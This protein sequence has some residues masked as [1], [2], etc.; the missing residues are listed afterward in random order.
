MSAGVSSARHIKLR[1]AKTKVSSRF[2]A[3]ASATICLILLLT[4]VLLN[5]QVGF[6]V[7]MNGEELGSAK[8]LDTVDTVVSNAEAKLTE[9]LGY[10]YD[11][12]DSISLSTTLVTG[13]ED[14]SKQLEEAI[15]GGIEEIASR[16]VIKVNGAVVGALTDENEANALLD[17]I[18]REY[19]TPETTEIGFREDVEIIRDYVTDDIIH[20]YA[21]LFSALNPQNAYSDYSL[22]VVAKGTRMIEEDIPYEVEYRDDASMYQGAVQLITAGVKGR[23]VISESFECINGVEITHAVTGEIVTKT[24]VTEVAVRGTAPRPETASK[25][26]FIWPTTGTFTSYFGYRD[27]VW[28]AASFHRGLDIAD[29]CGTEIVAADGGLVIFSGYMDSYGN[30]VKIQH[31]NGDVTW[32][33]HCDEL[34]VEEGE[35][36]CQGELIAYMG[37]SGDTTGDHLHFEVH[38]G[39]GS[40]V[41]PLCYLPW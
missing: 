21:S 16:A 7:Y 39:G 9:L 4:I 18:L 32:Y 33:A 25:G 29:S 3:M 27:D 22:T 30:I 12:G 24:P 36:V 19:K 38:P 26:V 23:K 14:T 2:V 28:F 40:A 10:E 31:D 13:R 5:V 1:G 11:L 6:A 8:D 34:L 37:G 17:S 41:D 35:R 15:I 20:T